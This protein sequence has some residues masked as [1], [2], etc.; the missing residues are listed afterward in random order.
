MVNEKIGIL[1]G[2]F[3]PVHN[4]HI[5]V[6]LEVRQRLALAK[7]IF[8]PAGNPW[9]KAGTAVSP[10]AQRVDMLRLAIAPYPGFELSTIE[11]ER[12]APSYSVDT[13]AELLT[14]LGSGV[15]LYFILGWDGLAQLPQWKEPA[16]LVR[17]CRLVAVPRPGY[18]LPDVA[19]LDKA[20]PGLSKSLVLLDS[21]RVDISASDIRHRVRH[22]LP[23]E[24]LVPEPVAAYIKKNRLYLDMKEEK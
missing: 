1:G 19:S 6:A 2:T 11:I 24:N 20:V 14:R 16:R 8:I 3:D 12:Q 7:I 13:V 10:A 5:A 21:P 15:E 22:G 4:G 18:N 17:L 9:L 23:F